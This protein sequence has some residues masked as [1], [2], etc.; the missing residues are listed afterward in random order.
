MNEQSCLKIG[1]DSTGLKVGGATKYSDQG[2]REGE[3]LLS[4]LRNCKCGIHSS[5]VDAFY[6]GYC[7]NPTGK[8]PES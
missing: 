4:G 7:G 3:L 8:I 6:L 1:A 5:E 2:E